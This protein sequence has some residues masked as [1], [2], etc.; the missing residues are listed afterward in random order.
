L[1]TT[2][3]SSKYADPNLGSECR[4]ADASE[5]KGHLETYKFWIPRLLTEVCRICFCLCRSLA[6]CP[7]REM[8][9]MIRTSEGPSVTFAT[10]FLAGLLNKRMAGLNRR[11]L[12]KAA[13]LMVGF[14]V[15]EREVILRFH[16][17]LGAECDASLSRASNG[18]MEQ[19]C[20]NALQYLGTWPVIRHGCKRWSRSK[21]G[22]MSAPSSAG[23]F[24][25]ASLGRVV[26][27]S[28]QP[29]ASMQNVLKCCE[30]QK[31]FH[32]IFRPLLSAF[33]PPT[34]FQF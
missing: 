34:H 29:Q 18:E 14:P 26:T 8:V 15:G 7:C 28:G 4:S 5:K 24:S 17:R 2:T 21:R 13:E 9:T 33:P 1:A 23:I 20:G 10:R 25:V 19:G 6:T 30:R 22:V 11:A 31:P 3:S 12:A 16:A 32:L 27:G